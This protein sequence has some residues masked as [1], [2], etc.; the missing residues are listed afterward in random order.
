MARPSTGAG[1][2]IADLQRILDQKQNELKKLYKRR[3]Q[4]ERELELRRSSYEK[5]CQSLEQT[6]IDDA[7]EAGRISNISIAEPPTVSHKPVRPNRW[8]ILV[9]S[10]M[11]ATIAALGVGLMSEQYVRA[12]S[13]NGLS[14]P[15]NGLSDPA[16]DG[17][18]AEPLSYPLP[19]NGRTVH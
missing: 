8:V 16:F 15:V 1:L 4:L 12:M 9:L 13:V 11:C 3:S 7:L 14:D 6:R 17:S 19:A 10:M 5:Y 2:A 18:T